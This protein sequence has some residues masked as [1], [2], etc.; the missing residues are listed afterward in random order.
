MRR[1]P[2]LRSNQAGFTIPEL[3]SVMVVTTI[4]SGLIIY[5]AFTYWRSSATLESDMET[6]V[7]RLNAGDSLR[8]SF[9][10]AT[11]LITQN[12]IP[13]SHTGKPD[14]AY[15]SNLYWTPI[16]A[17][18]GNTAMPASGSVTPLVYYSRP[19]V[20]SSKNYIMNGTQPYLNE[21]I[22]YL[23]GS[24]KKLRQRTLANPAATGNAALT[25]C[26]DSAASSSCPADR[27][28]A[29]DIQ[30]IDL[31]YFSRTGNLIDYSSII[32]PLD[33]SYIGPDFPAVEVVE[34]NLHTF[35]KSIV[36]GGADTS[37]QTVIRIALRN[38]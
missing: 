32:D 12:S 6:Y 30:S 33:G 1:L 19:A 38:G 20:D 7:S 4:F 8:D 22:L 14:P 5:F 10:E 11:G 15:P 34:F 21:Y 31:R 17:I 37:S 18:P 3:I 13:D 23:D 16:H 2:T 27:T 26:P 9:N 24:T 36:H 28:I 25:T 35:R 29:E